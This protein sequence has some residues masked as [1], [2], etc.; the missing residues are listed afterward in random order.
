MRP[1]PIQRIILRCNGPL[2]AGAEAA[3][4]EVPESLEELVKQQL[5][6]PSP[7]DRCST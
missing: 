4:R 6:Q 7:E 3:A 5:S 2:R 1:N